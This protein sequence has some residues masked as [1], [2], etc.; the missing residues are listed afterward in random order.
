MDG[1]TDINT[2]DK[3]EERNYKEGRKIGR[4]K[5]RRNNET[6]KPNKEG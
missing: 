2:N 4:E 1:M 6:K 3:K 5:K